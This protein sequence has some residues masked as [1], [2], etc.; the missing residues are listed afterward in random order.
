MVVQ[1]QI[2]VDGLGHVDA[3]QG[4]AR[5]T[6]LLGKNAQGVGRIVAADI[7]EAV[8]AVGLERSK[9]LAAVFFIGLVAGRTKRRG[10]RC[11]H[12][13]EIGLAFPGQVCKILI[14]DAAY[15]MKSTVDTARVFTLTGLQHHAN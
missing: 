8:D 15:A 13:L 9:N 5:F 10:G 1:H 6:R 14:H 2:V 7:E 12:L 3:A 11:R 4:V